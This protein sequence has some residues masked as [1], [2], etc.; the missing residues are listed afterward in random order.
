[1]KAAWREKGDR[2][3]IKAVIAFV[4]MRPRD[5]GRCCGDGGAMVLYETEF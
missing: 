3:N 1:L 4:Y 5:V 2:R